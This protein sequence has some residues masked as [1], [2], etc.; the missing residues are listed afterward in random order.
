[1]GRELLNY[2]HTLGHAV[3]AREHYTWRHGAAVAVGMVYAA[4]LARLT[5]GTPDGFVALHREVLGALGLPTGYHGAAFAE[6]RG[7]LARDKKARGAKLR[8]VLL[9]AQADPFVLVGPEESDLEA[10]YVRIA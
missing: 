2:G 5:V 6:L 4:E 10:A 7:I 8:F 9:R 3:E 1:V